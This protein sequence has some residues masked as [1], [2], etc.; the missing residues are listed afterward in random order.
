MAAW[1]VGI[2]LNDFA[3]LNYTPDVVGG[4]HPVGSSHLPNSVR[5]I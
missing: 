5:E 4:Y 2:I 1:I 3:R